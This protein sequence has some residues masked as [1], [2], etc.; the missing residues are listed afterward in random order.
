MKFREK[1]LKEYHE[2]VD[3]KYQA[4]CKGCPF[5]YG[6]ESVEDS[7]KN[8]IKKGGKGC[9]FCWDREIPGTEPTETEDPI[10]PSYYN[11]TKIS[12]IDVIDDWQLDFY[13][14]ST[15]KYIKRAGKKNGNSAIQDLKKVAFYIERE[16]KNLEEAEK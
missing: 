9:T 16:I 10:K 14:G 3:G 13:L 2:F 11:D 6:Y 1:L 15:L 7:R 4:E 8:C 5:N 12:P